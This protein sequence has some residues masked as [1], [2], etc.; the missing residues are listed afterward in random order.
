MRAR[1][2]ARWTHQKATCSRPRLDEAAWLRGPA[3]HATLPASALSYLMSCRAR[4]H[5]TPFAVRGH[6][7]AHESRRDNDTQ[8]TP[9]STPPRNSSSR[10]TG[11]GGGVVALSVCRARAILVGGASSVPAKRDDALGLGLARHLVR[12]VRGVRPGAR[13]FV[14]RAPASCLQPATRGRVR[15]ASRLR[16]FPGHCESRAR[17]ASPPCPS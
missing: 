11:S 7:L 8:S 13:H 12:G 6:S 4:R 1:H 9:T 14:G 5:H 17:R 15:V 16:C 3:G 2:R 10:A